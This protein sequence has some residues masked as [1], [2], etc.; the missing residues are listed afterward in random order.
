MSTLIN[1]TPFTA[2]FSSAAQTPW[3]FHDLPDDR[4]VNINDDSD[5]DIEIVEVKRNTKPPVRP[6]SPPLKPKASDPRAVEM[7]TDGVSG[8]KN[9]P[10][11][12]FSKPVRVAQRTP[13][14][15]LTGAQVGGQKRG[16]STDFKSPQAPTRVTQKAKTSDQ[17]TIDGRVDAASAHKRARVQ[18]LQTE[19]ARKKQKVEN[20][21][22][23]HAQRS[24]PQQK[25]STPLPRGSGPNPFILEDSSDDEVAPPPSGRTKQLSH[26]SSSK[27]ATA[28]TFRG[29][30]AAG[31]E[32]SRL[33]SSRLRREALER[34]NGTTHRDAGP[35]N[36]IKTT[37]Q[38]TESTLAGTAFETWEQAKMKAKNMRDGVKLESAAKAK[39]L[40]KEESP[41][42]IASSLPPGSKPGAIRAEPQHAQTVCAKSVDAKS[43]G[44]YGQPQNGVRGFFS[45]S[46]SGD[47]TSPAN[48]IGT[49]IQKEEIVDSKPN[50]APPIREDKLTYQRPVQSSSTDVAVKTPEDDA[51][52]TLQ[53]TDAE[54]RRQIRHENSRKKD[55]RLQAQI[56]AAKEVQQRE[57][58][59]KRDVEAAKVEAK[60]AATAQQEAAA[61]T[62]RE[63]DAKREAEARLRQH[64]K[65]QEE[66]NCYLEAKQAQEAQ[67]EAVAN[68]LAERR[69]EQDT[70]AD[71]NAALA[72]LQQAK[73]VADAQRPRVESRGPES[74]RTDQSIGAA[75]RPSVI[76]RP[77]EQQ[78][79]PTI[80]DLNKPGGPAPV[81][82]DGITPTAKSKEQHGSA[83]ATAK[84]PAESNKP[85]Q[86]NATARQADEAR[87][88]RIQAMKERNAKMRHDEEE[89]QN[90]PKKAD[91]LA[92]SL[93][94][95]G[96]VSL[97]SIAGQTLL[98]RP[99][100]QPRARTSP[101]QDAATIVSDTPKHSHRR[102]LG[103]ILPEDMHVMLRRDKGLKLSDI[104]ITFK[105]TFGYSRGVKTL[106]ARYRQVKE[107]ISLTSASR[108][109]LDLVE[110]GQPDARK[111]LNVLVHGTWPPP[112]R[113]FANE[114]PRDA[115][116][117]F[118]AAQ[119]P[120]AGFSDTGRN[121]RLSSPE[122]C[123]F[124]SKT[125]TQWT[126]TALNVQDHAAGADRPTTGGK[127]YTPQ[128]AQYYIE[129]FADMMRQEYEEEMQPER[130]PSPMSDEDYCH[131]AYRIQRRELSKDQED[132]GE[133]IDDIPW[134]ACGKDSDNMAQQNATAIKY[135]LRHPRGS[136]YC[137]ETDTSDDGLLSHEVKWRDGGI[138][139]VRLCRYMRTFQ[140]RILP[141]SKEGWAPKTVF[142]VKERTVT[143]TQD[144]DGMFDENK[145]IT[146]EENVNKTVYTT[147]SMANEC[148]AKRFVS[149]TFEPTSR[150]L[151][152][153]DAEIQAAER[154][155]LEKLDDDEG[156]MFCQGADHDEEMVKT[157]VWVEEGQLA[158]PRNLD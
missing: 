154:Q 74:L 38:K 139:Q 85:P 148:A 15:R 124:G 80:R 7:G 73:K 94:P 37:A 5:S 23:N 67:R 3:G 143:K 30:D 33:E 99:V 76:D 135:A 104:A 88:Q 28:A 72:C 69:K 51:K 52:P 138:V 155:L 117:H 77:T 150:H 102:Q 55:E 66:K 32:A 54:R 71:R 18:D 144:D 109:L 147:L 142:W 68:R 46:K 49:R 61:K 130:E 100:E 10:F 145:E 97:N 112:S 11:M 101:Q 146:V 35:S 136:N 43:P 86:E 98:A 128:I 60:K 78:A 137:L 19:H 96:P 158:G 133:S 44:S 125:L 17:T 45:G 70:V 121:R 16:L 115:N 79:S 58:Q 24:K 57:E 103:E 122:R 50:I 48:L 156:E 12:D 108:A 64:E 114:R 151:N 95:K 29:H 47:V 31:K 90:E 8:R 131:F 106:R 89:K 126:A 134:M 42:R 119:K 113:T 129:G 9:R 116:G 14:Q 92:P 6:T 153:R 81:M 127:S 62:R 4:N 87:Q 132:D 13:D 26:V 40:K 1:Q 123:S 21:M 110:A 149:L 75:A 2:P 59:A 27:P 152:T 22:Q 91:A 140:E 56:Q 36:D 34:K 105:K 118:I 25:P 83:L 111:E 157:C 65:Q 93:P 20:D 120:T 84:K 141:Q 53:D 107:A 39:V 82:K 63:A 41:T